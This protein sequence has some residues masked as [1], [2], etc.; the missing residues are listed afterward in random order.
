MLFILELAFVA[1]FF[2]GGLTQVILPLWNNRPVFPIFRR[3]GRLE[4]KLKEATEEVADAEMEKTIT[5]RAQRAEALRG[6]SRHES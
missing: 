4:H 5:K 6:G 1:L 2:Y 3:S